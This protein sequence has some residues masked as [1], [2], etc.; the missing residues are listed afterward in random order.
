MMK[1]GSKMTVNKNL[2]HTEM[3]QGF[4]D[5]TVSDEHGLAQWAGNSF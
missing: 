5:Q 3:L 4:N 1:I 2:I